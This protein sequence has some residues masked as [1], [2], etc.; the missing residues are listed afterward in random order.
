MPGTLARCSQH[1]C[2]TQ[3]HRQKTR[4]HAVTM[5]QEEIHT[6]LLSHTSVYLSEL[7]TSLFMGHQVLSTALKLFYSQP[8]STVQCLLSLSVLCL[9]IIWLDLTLQ[10]KNKPVLKLMINIF[11][12]IMTRFWAGLLTR[13]IRHSGVLRV[14]TLSL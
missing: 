7:F 3:A 8:Q 14:W 4:L 11:Y 2:N 9:H 1:A 12:T 6:Q 10:T 13:P 5:N